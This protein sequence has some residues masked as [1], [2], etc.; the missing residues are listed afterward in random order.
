MLDFRQPRL[1]DARMASSSTAVTLTYISAQPTLLPS[2]FTCTEQVHLT[3]CDRRRSRKW[4]CRRLPVRRCNGH[5]TMGGDDAENLRHRSK[6]WQNL[7]LGW[8]LQTQGTDPP[9]RCSNCGGDG[10]AECKAC[11]AT[12]VLMLGDRLMC[13][14]E[15]GCSCPVCKGGLV[16]CQRCKGSGRIAAWLDVDW[17][18]PTL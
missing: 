6:E 13:S 4:S 12:G 9:H 11:H 17:T 5:W 3:T 10:W 8:R 14:I 2:S 18:A 16:P 1:E 7:E 15:G